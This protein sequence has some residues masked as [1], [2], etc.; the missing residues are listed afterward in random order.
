MTPRKECHPDTT[1]AHL[2]SWRLWQ[3]AKDLQGFRPVGIWAI[4]RASSNRIP[5]NPNQEVIWNWYPIAKGKSGFPTE[6]RWVH[7][8]S[9][10]GGRIIANSTAL[11][12]FRLFW[13]IL[14]LLVFWLLIL[15]FRFC[16]F[17]G[18]FVFLFA[19]FFFFGFGCLLVCLK[20]ERE[21]EYEAVWVG[22]WGGLGE[23]ETWSMYEEKFFH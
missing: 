23:G 11:V 16:G 5:P 13:H 6:S 8:P 15:I 19:F 7:R 22:G 3:H 17:V 1:G 4:R 20:K 18:L 2:N 9:F 21:R 10:R 14:V 12:M